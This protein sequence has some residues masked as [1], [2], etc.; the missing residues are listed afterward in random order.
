MG[1]SQQIRELYVIYWV[2]EQ[3]RPDSGGQNQV[4]LGYQL[5]SHNGAIPYYQVYARISKIIIT[6]ESATKMCLNNVL[7][8]VDSRIV[9]KGDSCPSLSY[10]YVMT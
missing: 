7:H 8:T 10:C 3:F 6:A 4:V 2:F 5:A 1:V 9:E